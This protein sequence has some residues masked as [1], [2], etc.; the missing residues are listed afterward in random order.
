M[1]SPGVYRDAADQ[2][3]RLFRIDHLELCRHIRRYGS[4]VR[5][6]MRVERFHGKLRKMLRSDFEICSF[7]H[8]QHSGAREAVTLRISPVG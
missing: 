7:V 6:G 4:V 3:R 5:F 1:L 2:E 8:R